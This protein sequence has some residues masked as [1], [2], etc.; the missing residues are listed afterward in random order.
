ME[1]DGRV[2]LVCPAVNPDNDYCFQSKPLVLTGT[3]L[4]SRGVKLSG[5]PST[6]ISYFSTRVSNWVAYSDQHT[7]GV[8]VIFMQDFAR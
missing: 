4:Q 6:F 2:L 1:I 3:R 5:S 8:N 7:A